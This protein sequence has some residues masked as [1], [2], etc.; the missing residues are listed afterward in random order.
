MFAGNQGFDAVRVIQYMLAPAVMI[1]ACGLLLLSA[2]NKYSNVVN[3]IRLIN[4][5]KRR[6]IH[7]AAEKDF[8]PEENLRLESATRQLGDLSIRALLVRNSVLSYTTAA[9]MFVLC[10]ISIGAGLFRIFT[11]WEE[12]SILVFLG[13]MIAVFVGVIFGVLE[14]KKGYEIVRLEVEAEQ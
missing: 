5:E 12:F 6:L 9:A 13:G 14:S 4:D 7:R 2:N 11:W 1:N 8:T 10:S 3:R